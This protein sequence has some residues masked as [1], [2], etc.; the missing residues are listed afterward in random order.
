MTTDTIVSFNIISLFRLLEL[1]VFLYVQYSRN[2]AEA[3][4]GVNNVFSEVCVHVLRQ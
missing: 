2:L 3:V 4:E 1:K